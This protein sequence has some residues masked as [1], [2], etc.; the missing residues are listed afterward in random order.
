MKAIPHLSFILGSEVEPEAYNYDVNPV[1]G[2]I[3]VV[4][5][6]LTGAGSLSIQSASAEALLAMSAAFLTAGGRLRGHIADKDS[7]PG[8]PTP[9]AEESDEAGSEPAEGERLN[10]GTAAPPSGFQGG[11]L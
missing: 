3:G 4:T 7:A 6:P 1:S 5:V 8:A 10:T 11:A 9:A 2:P